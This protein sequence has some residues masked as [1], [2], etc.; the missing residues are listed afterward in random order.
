MPTNKRDLM[1][2]NRQLQKSLKFF[3]QEAADLMQ[4]F[5]DAI[6][7]PKGVVPASGE[8]FYDPTYNDE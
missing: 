5:H 2:A 6:E 1:E 3:Q 4:A 7:R 8:R